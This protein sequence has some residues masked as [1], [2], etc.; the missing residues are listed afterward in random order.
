MRQLI[1]NYDTQAIQN[2][3]VIIILIIIIIIRM[4]ITPKLGHSVHFMMFIYI[5][6][7]R[8]SQSQSRPP[9]H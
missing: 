5:S 2:D 7:P 1:S 9:Y 8:T 4:I 3:V 6:V